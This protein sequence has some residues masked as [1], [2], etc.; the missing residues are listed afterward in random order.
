M[1]SIQLYTYK[2]YNIHIQQSGLNRVEYW[3]SHILYEQVKR[4]YRNRCKK[5]KRIL[6][7]INDHLKTTNIKD[8]TLF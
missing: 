3:P 4:A 7:N 5:Q 2:I 8:K 1:H 6:Q